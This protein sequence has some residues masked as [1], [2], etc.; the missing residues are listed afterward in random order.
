MSVVEI[1]CLDVLEYENG[2]TKEDVVEVELCGMSNVRVEVERL[3]CVVED[4][5]RRL[6]SD[7][8]EILFRIKLAY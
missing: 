8:E 7:E 4:S 3:E 1:E 2:G 6:L 5:N